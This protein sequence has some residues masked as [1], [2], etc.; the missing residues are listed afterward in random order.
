MC[1][2][3]AILRVLRQRL[4]HHVD[5]RWWD[6]AFWRYLTRIGV[7]INIPFKVIDKAPFDGPITLT[8]GK[9]RIVIGSEAARRI[10]V[11]TV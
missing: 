2:L 9:R 10:L 3:V 6:L 8:G 5:Q 11:A 1:V 7:K 4:H